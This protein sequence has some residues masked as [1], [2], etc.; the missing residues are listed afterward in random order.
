M[1]HQA[2]AEM[3]GNYGEFFGSIAVLGTLLYLAIQIRQN[4]Y[5]IERDSIRAITTDWQTHFTALATDQDLARIVRRA[6][7]DWDALDKNEQMRAHVFLS[8][9]F[10]HYT[11]AAQTETEELS[12]FVGGWEDNMVGLLRTPGGRKWYET[13]QHWFFPDVV[14]RLNQRLNNLDAA[15]PAWNSSMTWWQIDDSDL[16]G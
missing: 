5:A 15:P 13:A 9:L 2:I 10:G 3:L 11:H 16:T 14:E 4:K 1:E 6:V 7:N 12:D 8:N